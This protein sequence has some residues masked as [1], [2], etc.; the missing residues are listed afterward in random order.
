MTSL[1]ETITVYT[2]QKGPEESS[3]PPDS[4]YQQT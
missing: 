2:G 4:R 1:F 3:V